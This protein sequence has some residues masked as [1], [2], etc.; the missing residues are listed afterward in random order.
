LSISIWNDYWL[1]CIVSGRIVHS[2]VT[3]NVTWVGDLM[4]QDLAQWNH[5]LVR[6]LFS[7]V[8][9]DRIL[10]I[11]LSRSAGDDLVG[12]YNDLDLLSWL[13]FL[14]QPL[15]WVKLALILT[16]IWALWWSRN[17]VVLGILR[18]ARWHRLTTPLVKANFDTA[19]REG[20]HSSC[21]RLV[22]QNAQGLV[23]G[24]C[25][26]IHG[27]A[28]LAFAAEA[29]ALLLALEFTRDLGLS[30]VLF[31]GDSLHMI[32]KLNNTQADCSEIRALVTKGKLRLITFF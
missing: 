25:T 24:A 30:R 23:F 22:V 17:R 5:T 14:C 21:S 31:E 13:G 9:T 3:T 11:P 15:T 6:V 29:L 27:H 10:S 19:Y 16:T 4:L 1:P 7:T 20:S 32:H 12:T 2:F 8:K 18:T 28:S 26:R